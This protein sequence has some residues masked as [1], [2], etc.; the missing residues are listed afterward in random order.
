MKSLIDTGLSR[1]AEN[2]TFKKTLLKAFR[3]ARYPIV[4]NYWAD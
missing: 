4:S 2:E 3:K 1:E